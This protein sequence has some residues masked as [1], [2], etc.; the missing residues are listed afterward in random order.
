[1]NGIQWFFI[2]Y[3]DDSNRMFRNKKKSW[4]KKRLSFV[5]IE[6]SWIIQISKTK[7]VK[8]VFQ[9]WKKHTQFDSLVTSKVLLELNKMIYDH[10]IPRK[11][12]KKNILQQ[13]ENKRRK[14][15][16]WFLSVSYMRQWRHNS[17][18]ANDIKF[19]YIYIYNICVQIWC[20]SY[21]ICIY[22]S[23]KN[24]I[25]RCWVIGVR[26]LIRAYHIENHWTKRIIMNWA[27]HHW[28]AITM[29]IISQKKNSLHAVP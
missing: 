10:H 16:R 13:K 8:T 1:M 4:I 14:C 3:F 28:K 6:T 15:G 18:F 12:R 21:V 29:R 11:I 9:W 5:S 25:E 17:K 27:V 19:G 20:H 23:W 26:K 2:G 22:N 24:C 7:R